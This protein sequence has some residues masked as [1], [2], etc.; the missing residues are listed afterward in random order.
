ML[1]LGF[2]AIT[3]AAGALY[4][5][6][7]EQTFSYPA[8]FK[9]TLSVGAFAFSDSTNIFATTFV[10]SNSAVRVNLFSWTAIASARR[11]NIV[12]KG[13]WF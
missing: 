4:S 7:A 11:V 13:K 8:A 5:G 9:D 1:D 6:A 2:G 10:P 12:A 3:T